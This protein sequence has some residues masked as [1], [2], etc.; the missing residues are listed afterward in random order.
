M[1]VRHASLSKQA[2]LRSRSP[3]GSISAGLTRT[4][5]PQ[6]GVLGF[7]DTSAARLGRG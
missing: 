5:R 4:D 7:R 1:P 6:M 3:A 2:V